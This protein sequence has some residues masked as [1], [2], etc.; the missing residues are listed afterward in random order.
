MA[1]KANNTLS[2]LKRNLQINN[3]SLKT[4]AYQTLVRPHI[5]YASTVW[6]PYTNSNI[7]RL[8]MVQ[9]KAARYVLNRYHNTSRGHRDY[10][11]ALPRKQTQNATVVYDVQ[12]SSW[13]NYSG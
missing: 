12:N 3:A 4:T 10:R 5:K 9:R 2:F 11:M 13:V 6:D 8:E 1:L 7:D